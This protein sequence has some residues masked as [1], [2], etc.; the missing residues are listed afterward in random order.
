MCVPSFLRIK[1][2][3]NGMPRG[4]PEQLAFLNLYSVFTRVETFKLSFLEKIHR[5]RLGDIHNKILRLI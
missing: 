5:L 4:A 2:K 1:H 3:E